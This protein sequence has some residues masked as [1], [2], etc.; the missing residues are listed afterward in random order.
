MGGSISGGYFLFTKYRQRGNYAEH[1]DD[2]DNGTATPP[3]YS[4]KFAKEKTD[5][6]NI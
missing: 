4:W 6:K 5:E 3:I 2:S 1:A